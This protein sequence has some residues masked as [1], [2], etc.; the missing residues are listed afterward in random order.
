MITVFTTTQCAY[1]AMVKKFL[2]IK[3]KEYNVVNLEENP[4]L[5]QS[6]IEKTGAMTV[7]VTQIGEEYIIGW[8]PAKLGALL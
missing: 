4:D 7:P 5:R 6:L 2:D 3:G 1:C 8:N